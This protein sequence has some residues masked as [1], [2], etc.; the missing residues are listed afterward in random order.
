MMV[1]RCKAIMAC[2]CSVYSEPHLSLHAAWLMCLQMNSTSFG[3][4]IC[5][6]RTADGR[7]YG[8]DD[9]HVAP[10]SVSRVLSQNAYMLF[11]QRD[12]PKPAPQPGFKRHK[13]LIP[14]A[15][16]APAACPSQ[17]AQPVHLANGLSEAA[18]AQQQQQQQ[19]FLPLGSEQLARV[20]TAPAALVRMADEPGSSSSTRDEEVNSSGELSHRLDATACSSPASTVGSGGGKSVAV[21]SSSNTS[22]HTDTGNLSLQEHA[23]GLQQLN[24]AAAASGM[25]QTAADE[26]S[27]PADLPVV[28]YRLSRAGPELLQLKAQLPGV[29]SAADVAVDVLNAG[30]QLQRLQLR[31]PGKFALLDVPLVQ[32]LDG[33]KQLV[34]GVCGKFYKRKQMLRLN[35]HLIDS[36]QQQ[37]QQQQEQGAEDVQQDSHEVSQVVHWHSTESTD[38]SSGSESDSFVMPHSSIRS[39]MSDMDL[40]SFLGRQAS[41]CLMQELRQQQQQQQDDTVRSEIASPAQSADDREPRVNSNRPGGRKTSGK[42]GSKGKKRR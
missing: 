29:N 10:T 30:P 35:L 24:P 18:V 37:Q 9:A 17:Q 39:V 21:A 13:P 36:S 14:A 25:Q 38:T 20:S 42:K 16:T 33:G 22:S 31:V 1:Q 19:V 3:H 15:I 28:G 12:V 4:Y 27:D 5:F 40:S 6:V 2:C 8:C 23:D 32:H 26:T 34:E 7:W 41:Q 11:Y